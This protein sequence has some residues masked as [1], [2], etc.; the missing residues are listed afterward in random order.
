M[1]PQHHYAR[2]VAAFF[3]NTHV[4]LTGGALVWVQ[5][6][7]NGWDGNVACALPT[8]PGAIL[9]FHPVGGVGLER[10][11]VGRRNPA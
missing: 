10:V 11:F 7:T 4:N 9:A 5:D 6:S 8:A 2:L 3:A 1:L